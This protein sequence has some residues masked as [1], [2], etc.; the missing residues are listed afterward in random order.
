MEDKEKPV[1]PTDEKKEEKLLTQAEVDELIKDRLARE[2]NKFAKELGIGEDFNKDDYKKYLD[3][4]S[5]QKTIKIKQVIRG[6]RSI[7][8]RPNAPTNNI[9]ESG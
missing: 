8:M 6:T 5:N 4:L 7:S 1:T 3:F 9:S 2:K